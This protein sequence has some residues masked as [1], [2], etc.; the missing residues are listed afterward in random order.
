MQYI[1]IAVFILLFTSLSI[2]I[3]VLSKS[4]SKS[5]EEKILLIHTRIDKLFTI[6][7]PA[8]NQV[9]K[10]ESVLPIE[11]Q[12]AMNIPPDVKFEVDGSDQVPQG[13]EEK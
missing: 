4:I 11:E 7:K 5:I 1:S 2:Y 8:E 13:Y 10:N 12:N 3:Y 6:D 9:G